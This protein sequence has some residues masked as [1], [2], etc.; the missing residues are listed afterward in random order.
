[1]SPEVFERVMKTLQ[2]VYLSR[3][4][5]DW[6]E[7]QLEVYY[8]TLSGFGDDEVQDALDKALATMTDTPMPAD[9]YR[10]ANQAAKNRRMEA[11]TNVDPDEKAQFPK[12]S[13]KRILQMGKA[14]RER[15]REI[16]IKAKEERQ[17]DGSMLRIW[18]DEQGR[19]FVMR[20]EPSDSWMQA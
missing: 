4:K 2:S 8:K 1:M 14:D 9:M 19:S 12:D 6:T 18:T 3:Y 10:L 11:G 7:G 20:L 16:M 15:M 13:I 17:P 5:Q